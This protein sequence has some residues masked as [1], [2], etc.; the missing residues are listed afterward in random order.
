MDLTGKRQE[1]ENLWRDRLNTAKE[2]YHRA[3]A[4]AE[5]ALASCGCDATSAQ[6]EALRQSQARESFA[7]EDYLQILRILHE[8]ILTRKRPSS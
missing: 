8:L 4:E 2:Q 6:I 1:L 3:R 5:A 7:L